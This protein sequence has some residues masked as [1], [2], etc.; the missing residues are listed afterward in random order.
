MR[1][2]DHLC[3]SAEICRRNILRHMYA[4][5]AVKCSCLETPPRYI[6]LRRWSYLPQLAEFRREVMAAIF[7]PT[8]N[9]AR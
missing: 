6:N 1:S 2:Y 8:F 4:E 3:L 5:G 9:S 7:S